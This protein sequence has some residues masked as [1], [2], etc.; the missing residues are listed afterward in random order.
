[1]IYP[2]F[3]YQLIDSG[4]VAESFCNSEAMTPLMR[5]LLEGKL[6]ETFVV[7]PSQQQIVIRPTAKNRYI[8]KVIVTPIPETATPTT[9]GSTS[10][11]SDESSE[12]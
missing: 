10:G 8:E 11:A 5:W 6:G 4:S 1:M 2:C 7:V 9:S 12:G 3:E